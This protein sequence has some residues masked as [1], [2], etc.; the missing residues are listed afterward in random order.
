MCIFNRSRAKIDRST[1][2]INSAKWTKAWDKRWEPKVIMDKAFFINDGDRSRRISM[3]TEY[4]VG[5][6]WQEVNTIVVREI[7]II[8][9]LPNLKS[10]IDLVGTQ[11]RWSI[12]IPLIFFN[13]N[14]RNFYKYKKGWAQPS[15]HNLNPKLYTN[16][17]EFTEEIKLTTKRRKILDFLLK[18]I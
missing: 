18:M 3:A 9:S 2:E 6:K 17:K 1:A 16:V 11:I 12:R 15:L 10:T 8:F 5:W 4:S 14:R 13:R 7:F